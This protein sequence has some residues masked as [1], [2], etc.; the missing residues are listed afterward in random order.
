MPIPIHRAKISLAL[1][2]HI[3][4]MADS[5]LMIFLLFFTD[6]TENKTNLQKQ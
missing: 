1:N 4:P 5:H 2:A 3:R 6:V